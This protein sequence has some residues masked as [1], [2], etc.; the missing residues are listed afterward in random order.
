MIA[1][2]GRKDMMDS[3]IMINSYL[4]SKGEVEA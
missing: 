2:R 1:V 3:N 4:I